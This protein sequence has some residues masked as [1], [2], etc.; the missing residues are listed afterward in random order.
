MTVRLVPQIVVAGVAA[1]M[2]AVVPPTAQAAPVRQDASLPLSTVSGVGTLSF[3][4][5][6]DEVTL[7][8]PV[9]Q[10]LSPAA[11][12]GTLQVPAGA[13]RG[14]VDVLSGGRVL[15][16]VEVPS[17]EPTAQV[18]LPL[19]GAAVVNNAAQVTLRSYLV[20]VDDFWCA[21]DWSDGSLSIVN[22]TVD[23]T[24][25]EAPPTV[26][27]D[28]LPPVLTRLSIYVPPEPT[29]DV[30]AAALEFGA[31]IAARYAN[32]DPAIELRALAPG[33]ALPTD[34]VGRLER[35]VVVTESDVNSTTLTTSP[36]GVP[37]LTLTGRADGLLNQTRLLT[38]NLSTITVATEATAGSLAAAPGIA[39][40]LTT[41]GDLG[42][43]KLTATST[44]RV[45]VRIGIDQ[46]KLGRPAGP[47]DV[48]LIGNYTPLPNTQNGQITITVGDT[49][50]DRWPV[51]A[52][53]RIDRWVTIPPES[54]SRYTELVVTLQVAGAMTCGSTQPVTL[55]LDPAGAVR[56]ETTLPPQPG[57]FQ[58]LPQSL[59]PTTQIGL[60]DGTFADARRAMTIVTGLQGLTVTPFRPELVDLD[61][62]VNSDSPAILIAADGGLPDSVPLPL[63]VTGD[64]TVELTNLTADTAPETVDV[65]GL[66][67]GSL[68][69]AWDDDHDR[70]LLVATSTDAPQSVDRI[71]DWLSA[72]RN[73]WSSLSGDALFQTG[74]RDPVTVSAEQPAP[75]VDETTG[76]VRGVL[77]AGGLLLLAGVAVAAAL[78]IRTR[79]RSKS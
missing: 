39:P 75:T 8:I 21:D 16:R 29:H 76:V 55:S 20:P 26:L 23:Y 71:L 56:S 25:D 59:M 72:D 5:R 17:G 28:Y 38:S 34:P 40:S 37:V 64:D 10:G 24:G 6:T 68:Q 79:R 62:A 58:A 36:A 46:T 67:F 65:P 69:A 45:Q 51:D 11:L 3:S 63:Q 42:A 73:R 32:Q 15:G 1:A 9:P 57:G 18:T 60:Q 35:Q 43:S 53:G 31:A 4:G 52:D 13:G 50:L 77:A 27:A 22:A 19:A 47:V 70:M 61:T 7:Q 30:T 12:R 78:L 74:D 2:V 44:G 48:H 54:M 33:A 49:T 41:L 66:R 14:W